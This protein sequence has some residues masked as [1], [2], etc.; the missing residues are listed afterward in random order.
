MKS[1]KAVA[2]SY[3]VMTLIVLGTPFVPFKTG[4]SIPLYFFAV[5]LFSYYVVS[6]YINIEMSDI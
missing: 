1:K 5:G 3:V 2:W 6:S 4:T